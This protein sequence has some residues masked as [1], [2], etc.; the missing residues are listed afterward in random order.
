MYTVMIIT[1]FSIGSSV[2]NAVMV[3]AGVVL[4]LTEHV[5]TTEGTVPGSQNNH[6][7]QNIKY[8]NLHPTNMYLELLYL[9][10]WWPWVL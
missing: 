10:P 5:E 8:K 3:V 2:S 1:T 6:D 4:S 7:I 9:Q